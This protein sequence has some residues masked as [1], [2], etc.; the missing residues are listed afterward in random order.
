MPHH[1]STVTV[2]EA[3]TQGLR[4]RLFAGEFEAGQELKDT[5]VAE[6][7]GIARPT[8]RTAVQQLINEG[9]LVR[10]PGG[11]ARVRTFD[12]EQ[13]RDLYRARRVIELDAVSRLK[14]TGDSLTSVERALEAF[15]K[16]KDNDD[17]AA[18]A[19]ADVRFHQAVVQ[20]GGSFR[21]RGFF[22][23]LT[24]ETRLL[25]ALLKAQYAG[26]EELYREHAELLAGL[27]DPGQEASGLLTTWGEHLDSARDFLA[28][29]LADSVPQH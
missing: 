23:A 21:L 10:P 12:A 5:Q 6:E 29:Y 14:E 13:V 20:A 11:S 7:F 25:I 19:E 15:S 18:I 17:W 16:T 8:A 1:L 24:S 26:G 2:A 3:A 27:A 4:D 28:E 22:E 9:M